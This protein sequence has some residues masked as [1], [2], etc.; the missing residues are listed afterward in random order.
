MSVNMHAI[1]VGL[2]S[3]SHTPEQAEHAAQEVL[4]QHAHEL[5][6]QLRQLCECG[7]LGR[8]YCPCADAIDPKAQRASTEGDNP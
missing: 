6:E 5:A 7:G 3:V 4:D 1:L 2:L 8:C